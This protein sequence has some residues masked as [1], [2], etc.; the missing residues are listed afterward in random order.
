MKLKR[1]ISKT[2]YSVVVLK[3]VMPLPGDSE[4]VQHQ[5]I[6]LAKSMPLG[7]ADESRAYVAQK[8]G[9]QKRKQIE[10]YQRNT[11]AL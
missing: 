11:P 7:G 9:A 2:G 1:L 4:R 8:K 6:T 10:A 5:K 3:S